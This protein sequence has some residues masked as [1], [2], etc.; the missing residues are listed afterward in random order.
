M[1]F[2]MDINS[3]GFFSLRSNNKIDVS[4][5]AQNIGKGGG[6]K[7]ASGGKIDHF[8]DSFILIIF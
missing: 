6:H 7:N 1:T 5:M 2:Y 3:R 4:N 8:K